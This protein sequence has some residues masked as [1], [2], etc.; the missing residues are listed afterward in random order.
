VPILVPP[1]TL[2]FKYLEPIG[3]YATT[4]AN[5][6][7]TLV[8]DA[9]A[10]ELAIHFESTGAAI[11]CVFEMMFQIPDDFKKFEGIATDIVVSAYQDGNSGDGEGDIALTV[12]VLDSAGATVDDSSIADIALTAAYVALDAPLVTG[13]TFVHGD[14][15]TI[16]ISII[17]KGADVSENGDDALVLFPKIKYIP[18]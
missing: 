10:D 17:T 8:N 7:I 13:G 3:F 11:N 14:Y 9:T 5:G 2:P 16:Q 15:I 4:L 18:Q 6:T 12:A 1:S